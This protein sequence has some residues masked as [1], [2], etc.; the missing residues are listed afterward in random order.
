MST[1]EILLQENEEN[2]TVNQKINVIKDSKI[3]LSYHKLFTATMLF[4]G[5]IWALISMYWYKWKIEINF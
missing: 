3:L 4:P 5:R 1:R 2:R